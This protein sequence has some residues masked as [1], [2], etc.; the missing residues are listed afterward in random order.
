MSDENLPAVLPAN[1]VPGKA[2]GHINR[3]GRRPGSTNEFSETLKAAILASIARVGGVEFLVKIAEEDPRTYC[4][5]LAK[6]LPLTI[7]GANGE[8]PHITV[9]VEHV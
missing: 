2:H 6:V 3:G 4:M 8:T 9:T 7:Q 1:T 5:L